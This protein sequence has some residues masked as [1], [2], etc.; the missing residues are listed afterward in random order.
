[1]MA[2]PGRRRP[3]RS[4]SGQSASNQAPSVS[5][6]SP[7]AGASFTAPANIAIQATSGDS[8]GRVTRVE[9]YRGTTLDRLRFDCTL[10]RHVD[11]RPRRDIHADGKSVRRGRRIAHFECGVRHRQRRDVPA[12][13]RGLCPVCRPRN[14]CYVIHRCDLSRQVLPRPLPSRQGASGSRG[15]ERRSLWTLQH[16]NPLPA[17][18]YYAVVRATGPGGTTPS[19]KS[20]N[21]TK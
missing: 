4:R 9:F 5:I 14:K 20:A 15:R 12:D 16:L 8:D 7:A 13:T 1:M 18:W 21:F 6:S 11:R 3:S 19:T 17:G 2:L 10:Q